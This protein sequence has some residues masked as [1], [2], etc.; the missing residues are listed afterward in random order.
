M[1]IFSQSKMDN[2]AGHFRGTRADAGHRPLVFIGL[3]NQSQGIKWGSGQHR[4]KFLLYTS[5][6]IVLSAGFINF[7]EESAI[8][9]LWHRPDPSEIVGKVGDNQ[10][11]SRWEIGPVAVVAGSI[12]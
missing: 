1:D 11:F 3:N 7:V 12:S 9:G 8:G 10:V 2:F 4:H 5:G 6:R